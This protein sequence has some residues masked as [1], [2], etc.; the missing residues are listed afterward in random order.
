MRKDGKIRLV[1]L[2]GGV[3]NLDGEAVLLASLRDLTDQ[4]AVEERLHQAQK[5]EAI[6]ALAGGIAHDFNNILSPILC[7]AEFAMENIN[8]PEEVKE[9]LD[10]IP[11]AAERAADLVKHILSFSR[12]ADQEKKPLPISVFV[13]EA[14]KFHRK[15]NVAPRI[16]TAGARF[17]G[18]D[19]AF[20]IGGRPVCDAPG[21]GGPW[22]GSPGS[23]RLLT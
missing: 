13:K 18:S 6:G 11:R 22:S 16:N 12:G 21:S 15:S 17:P 20:R 19:P 3:M 1:E 4:K 9:D 10:E 2:S 8:E 23:E 14:V 5:M 7:L